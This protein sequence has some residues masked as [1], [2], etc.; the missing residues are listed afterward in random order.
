VCS[1]CYP[2]PAPSNSMTRNYCV[3]V[4]LPAI[5]GFEKISVSHHCFSLH[6]PP[7]YRDSF[8]PA[9]LLLFAI[10]PRFIPIYDNLD[11]IST[12]KM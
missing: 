7:Y 10:A 12:P 2:M 8:D 11:S 1:S 4:S 5:V 3:P 9:C 6:L